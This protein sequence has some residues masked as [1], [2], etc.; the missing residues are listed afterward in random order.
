MGAEQSCASDAHDEQRQELCGGRCSF[1]RALLRGRMQEAAK[2]VWR[3]DIRDVAFILLRLDSAASQA[4]IATSMHLRPQD[5]LMQTELRCRRVQSASE[6]SH[7]CGATGFRDA[8]DALESVHAQDGVV[9]VSF[10]SCLQ[11]YE[12]RGAGA[13]LHSHSLNAVAATLLDQGC[14]EFRATHLEMIKA[15]SR[16][17]PHGGCPPHCRCSRVPGRC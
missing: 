8:T 11:A 16:V 4:G 15:R 14:S 10:N 9:K 17:P 6:A 2:L 7:S 12:L 3:P 5:A 1:A 13:V